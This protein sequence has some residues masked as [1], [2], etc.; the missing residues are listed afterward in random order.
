M[1]KTTKREFITA[2]DYVPLE[3]KFGPVMVL[4]TD[5]EHFNVEVRS[6][7]FFI[8]GVHFCFALTVRVGSGLAA[9]TVGRLTE[10][11]SGGNLTPRRRDRLLEEVCFRVDAAA[12]GPMV[13]ALKDAHKRVLHNNIR[14]IAEDVE[15][16]RK[17][18]DDLIA[19]Q[20][21]LLDEESALAP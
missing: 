7:V 5:G 6:P 9:A 10:W 2:G 16:A 1:T 14:S 21:S 8:D 17:Q 19:V 3:T 15:K 18:L 4:P 13:Q 20:A 11:S 12:H